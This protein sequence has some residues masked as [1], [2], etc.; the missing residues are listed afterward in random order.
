MKFIF[1][2]FALFA[3]SPLFALLPYQSLDTPDYYFD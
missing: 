2:F 1:Y 3:L